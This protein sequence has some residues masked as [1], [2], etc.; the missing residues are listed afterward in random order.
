MKFIA[1]RICLI[2]IA[3]CVSW[4][5]GV[6]VASAA[7]SCVPPSCSTPTFIEQIAEANWVNLDLQPTQGTAG[8]K[9]A[10]ALAASTYAN[11]PVRIRLAAGTY[12]DNLGAEIFAQRLQRNSTTPIWLVG[13][14]TGTIQLEQ[15]INL[16]GVSYLAIEG[17]T[18]G[19]ETVGAWNA[20]SHTH[21]APQ[22]LQA[23]AGIHI[24]GEALYANQA[25]ASN[26]VLNTAI[27]GKY[28]PSHHILI[29][30]VTIRNVFEL[31]AE[32][33]EASIGQGMDGMKF[34]QVEDLWV[35]NSSVRQTSRHGI[36]N[37]GVH[38]AVF[39][40]NVIA[41]TG[42]GQGIEAKGG[43]QDILL[44]S[45]VFYKVRRVELGGESTDATYYFSLDGLWNY[46]ALRMVA[47]NNLII[48]AREAGIEFAGCTDCT[49]VGNTIVYSNSYRAPIDQ[50]TVFG[51]DAIRVHDS[52]VLGAAEG[53][54]SDCQFWNGSDYVTVNPCWGVGAN[55]PAPVQRVLR[56]SNVTVVDNVFASYAAHFSNALGGSTIPCPLNVVDGTAELHFNGNYWYNG[57]L[58]LPASGCTALPE[59][60][61]SHFSTSVALAAP[62]FSGTLDATSISSLRSSASAW[63]TPPAASPL[64]SSAIANSNLGTLDYLGHSR[65]SNATIGAIVVAEG[66]TGATRVF[67]GRRSDYTLSHG[68]NGFSLVDANGASVNISG[69]QRLIFSDAAIALDIDGVAAQ[70]YRIY[71][72]A[73]NRTPDSGGLGYW[74]KAM[75]GNA[76]VTQ[77]AGGFITSAEFI[78]LY[79]SN[80]SDAQFVT[81]LYSNVLHRAAEGPGYNYW[82]DTLARG[83]N[84]AEVLAAFSESAENKDQVA[85]AISVGIGYTP[86]P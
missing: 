63:L 22:P 56:S 12:A 39:A 37:V 21:S 81:R 27:Y 55:A 28:Q 40:N 9:A 47:R 58:A 11:Q 31:D 51:G 19:P 35:L 59:G 34:N 26:G 74:L 46:E 48:D 73:F 78:A 25:G 57:A 52:A 62:G 1:C 23:Q 32:S 64:A 82:I 30:N 33:G 10:L 53:A 41:N 69:A 65:A 45:N 36:D 75:D 2:M 70:A 15:G 85:A 16:L 68:A 18:I 84:R 44:D 54:G 7:D 20:T 14:S 24:A 61:A 71:Q 66:Q 60:S 49:A 72:A 17:I 3:C 77:V 76:T 50:G 38:R 29:R 80:P 6:K 4:G 43:A 67:T 79:G 8:I 83:A 5:G 86:Y 42:G 13:A